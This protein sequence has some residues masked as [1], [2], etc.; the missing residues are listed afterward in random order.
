MIYDER[1]ISHEET[2]QQFRGALRG[3]PIGGIPHNGKG[4]AMVRV[5][6]EPEVCPNL[7]AI[8]EEMQRHPSVALAEKGFMH[9]CEWCEA[10]KRERETIPPGQL[11]FDSVDEPKE[12]EPPYDLTYRFTLLPETK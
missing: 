7:L 2:D 3:C 4:P 6:P 10:R 11:R 8:F 12:T 1:Q 5:R 9:W